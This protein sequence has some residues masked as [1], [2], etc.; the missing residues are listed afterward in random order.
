[1]KKVI[2][3]VVL[4]VLFTGCASW[5]VRDRDLACA[6]N[7]IEVSRCDS[8]EEKSAE[9]CSIARQFKLLCQPKESKAELFKQLKEAMEKN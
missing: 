7:Q 4:F 9:V 5:N 2:P 8:G 6:I 3:L 1:M